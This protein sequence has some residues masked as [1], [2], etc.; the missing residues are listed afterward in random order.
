MMDDGLETVYGTGDETGPSVMSERVQGI[1]A[2]IY[3]E[4]E[5]MI[6][7]YDEDVVKELMPLV[8]NVLETLE[9]TV[10]ENQEH[11]V[12]LELIKDDNEQ[13]ITQYEREKQLRKQSEQKFLEYED[14]NDQE[15]RLLQARVEQMEMSGKQTGLKLKNYSDQISRHEHREND[16]KLE[17][18][19]LQKRHNEVVQKYLEYVDRVKMMGQVDTTTQQRFRM[20][21]ELGSP[22]YSRGDDEINI[23]KH[24]LVDGFDDDQLTP[25][26]ERIMSDDLTSPTTTPSNA[27][28][29]FNDKSNEKNLEKELTETMTSP[30]AAG[31]GSSTTET[32]ATVPT[33]NAETVMTPQI[34]NRHVLNPALRDIIASTPELNE[35]GVTRPAN[36]PVKSQ[37]TKSATIF[38]ELDPS[39]ISEMDEGANIV[40]D[41]GEF[42]GMGKEV[43]NILMENSELRQTK[44]ALNV[45][46]DDLIA[47][48]DELTSETEMLKQE[49][50]SINNS[51]SRLNVRITD[52]EEELKKA[53][54]E[55]EKIREIDDE[56]GVPMAQ[57]KRFTRVEMARVLMERNQYKERLMELQEAVRWTEM[58]RASREHPSFEGKKN[59]SSIWK[60]F[61]NLFTSSSS[62]SS[63][64]AP[65][66]RRNYPAANVRYNAPT[67]YVAPNNKQRTQTIASLDNKT[68]AFDFLEDGDGSQ[69][70]K[71]KRE[72]YKKVK[73]HVRKDDGRVQAYGWSLPAKHP[74]P[75][76]SPASNQSQVDGSTAVSTGGGTG[77]GL[78]GVPVPV[79]CRPLLEKEPGTKIWCAAGVDLNGG[80]TR[81]GGAIIGASVFYSIP[82]PDADDSSRSSKDGSELD[83]LDEEITKQQKELDKHKKYKLSSLVWICTSN[84]SSTKVTV[85]DANQPQSILDMFPVSTAYVLCI[86]SVPGAMES[87]YP[88]DE[89]LPS[90]TADDTASVSSAG[91]D[92]GFGNVTL[93]T[94]SIPA[95]PSGTSPT[96]E[97]EGGVS[98]GD[99]EANFKAE[100]SEANVRN[101]SSVTDAEKA[102]REAAAA[103]PLPDTVGMEGV[104]K[105]NILKTDSAASS[106]TEGS[107]TDPLGA[108]TEP[109]PTETIVARQRRGT[110][111]DLLKDGLSD[112]PTVS[113]A[114]HEV[115]EKMTSIKPT[116][117]LGAQNGNLYVHSAVSQWRR[118]LHAIKLKDAIFAIVHIKGRVLAALADGTVAVFHRS[119]DGQWDLNNYHVLDLGKP[120]NSIRC[121]VVV[122]DRVWCGI[123]N[124]IH[125]VHPQ[126]LKVE[127]SF[128]AHPR[129]ESQVRLLSWQGD[130]VWVSIRLDST[131]RLYHAHTHQHLQD[132][133][134]EP[135]VSKMLGTGKLGFSFVR[136][137][138]V[139]I[140][141]NRLW[142]GTGNGVIISIPLSESKKPA[143]TGGSRPGGVIRVYT[144]S[145]TDNVRA[146]STIPYCSI[147]QAQLSFH[148]HRDAV[149]FFVSVPGNNCSASG[150]ATGSVGS[151]PS[152]SNPDQ[153]PPDNLATKNMLVLSGGEGYIDFR[154]GDGDDEDEGSGNYGDVLTNSSRSARSERSH[155][156]VWQI[157]GQTD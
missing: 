41:P 113:D 148:G 110:S 42:S 116:M 97:P 139:M 48:V 50:T 125:V 122:L 46:K 107:A 123:R 109:I 127:K 83:K 35:G 65:P 75:S 142:V 72:Q 111:S 16:M 21:H 4:F 133:D 61:S 29:K 153:P 100:V 7:T 57:R 147:T 23:Q 77:R 136:I 68:K 86:A 155:L 152:P 3:R 26:K 94:A 121:M 105:D 36:L 69:R 90:E 85:I 63:M 143:S 17:Y 43:E 15:K 138:S 115:A 28:N 98:L 6:K 18:Q 154:I 62:S 146:G 20:N 135:Y 156:I 119:A 80:R 53:R 91:S 2:S 102:L 131:L 10:T 59:K 11:E 104:V 13:L 141:C 93:V 12:E 73:A 24:Q 51:K 117:W 114:M 106:D 45:V 60:F 99:S 87:D 66:P 79:F 37:G 9:N 1:A 126:T 55:N 74:S 81:D 108:T 38:D 112:A 49:I 33:M 134:I 44:N 137:T 84:Q 95:T 78:M 120:Q 25:T 132:V 96:S 157:A 27:L 5:R 64:A 39:V 22:T 32:Q 151:A 92:S 70:I 54:E 145:K 52:L 103:E 76:R 101:I 14:V 31:T 82:D 150:I 149:K 19:A 128:D 67:G 124:K 130:G 144:D 118:C 71:D 129:K 30:I 56:E 89:D 88:T 140:S 34:D 47:Q 40:V 8:V 58:I